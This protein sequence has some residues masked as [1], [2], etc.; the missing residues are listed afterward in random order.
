MSTPDE[1]S[2]E[3]A[4]DRDR[5]AKCLCRPERGSSEEHPQSAFRCFFGQTA[6]N[7]SGCC[8]ERIH[9]HDPVWLPSRIGGSLP[10]TCT[11]V[12][13][14]LLAFSDTL[15]CGRRQQS[16]GLVDEC[17]RAGLQKERKRFCELAAGFRASSFCGVCGSSAQRRP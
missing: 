1:A 17:C 16:L 4:H 10:L 12:G 3:A 8:L 13:K 2:D 15:L 5:A 9:G 6:R 7:S 11:G 14:A